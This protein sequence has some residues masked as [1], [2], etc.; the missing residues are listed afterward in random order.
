[1][2]VLIGTCRDGRSAVYTTEMSLLFRI[3]LTP[4]PLLWNSF[5]PEPTDASIAPG[6][7]AEQYDWLGLSR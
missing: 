3:S 4:C 1:M 6:L 7:D 2:V 5:G